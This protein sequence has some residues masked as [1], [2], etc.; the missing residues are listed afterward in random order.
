MKKI[1]STKGTKSLELSVEE[2]V[3]M[4]KR[5]KKKESEKS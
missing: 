5:E 4:K 2:N 3:K 1:K